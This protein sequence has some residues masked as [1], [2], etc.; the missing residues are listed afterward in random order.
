MTRIDVEAVVAG[1]FDVNRKLFRIASDLHAIR[2]L[3]EDGDE[4]EEEETAG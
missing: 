4:E 2:V 3:L 1:M